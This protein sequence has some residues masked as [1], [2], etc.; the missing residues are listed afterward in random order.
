MQQEISNTL[1][2]N[3][4]LLWRM[5]EPIPEEEMAN[6]PEGLPNHPAWLLGH[7]SHSLE[8]IGGELG[9]GPWLDPAWT[10]LFA[11]G[12]TPQRDRAA[13]PAKSALLESLESGAEKIF[14]R[15]DEMS[16][17]DCSA[18]LPDARYR[19]TFPTIGHAVVHIL[20]SH[21][22]LHMGQLSCWLRVMGHE[23]AS[24][25]DER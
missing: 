22:A 18:P 7:L 16:D 20:G 17:D 21:F 5:T 8:A 19:D 2:L 12:S 9:V 23:V 25:M 11:T 6:Q 3:M 14:G 1:I 15:L 24:E 13:Y 4:R 10:E